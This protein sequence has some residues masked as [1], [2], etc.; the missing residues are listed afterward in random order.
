MK[1]GMK[2]CSILFTVSVLILILFVYAYTP[3]NPTS[4]YYKALKHDEPVLSPPRL[5]SSEKPVPA[6]AWEFQPD[7]DAEDYGLTD[8][9]CSSAF[10]KLFI[11]IDKA[12]A[13]R[14]NNPI[15]MEELDSRE[16]SNGLIR[17]MIFN[18]EVGSDIP[19]H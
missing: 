10:P 6:K 11:E 13:R 9:Q 1:R 15:T 5:S 8:N 17:G 18:A 12:V 4:N 19:Y 2:P 14:E 7:R 16:K 3:V